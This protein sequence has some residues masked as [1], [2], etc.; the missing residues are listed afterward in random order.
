VAISA[1]CYDVI[2][3]VRILAVVKSERK[4]VEVERQIFLANV[5]I[6]ADNVSM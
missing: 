2:E 3:D 5:V 4:F 1:S 6:I